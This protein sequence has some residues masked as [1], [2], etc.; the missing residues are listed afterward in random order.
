MEP[1]NQRG[2]KSTQTFDA[3][4]QNV[5]LTTFTNALE[6]D[7][8]RLAGRMSGANLLIW[9]SGEFSKH[10]G[11]GEV[12]VAPPEGVQL[13]VRQTT[14]PA[15]LS[16]SSAK[17]FGP[18]SPNLPTSPVP[19]GADLTYTFGPEWVDVAP[20]RIATPTTYAEFQGR[21]AYGERSDIPFHVN[22]SDW[23]DSDRVFAGILTAFGS[24]TGAIPIGG[25]GTFDGVMLN[26]FTRPRIEGDFTGAE[27]TAWDV[28]WG[29]ASGSAIIENSYANVKNVVISKGDSMIYADGLFSLGYPRKDGG[30]QLD[31]RVRIAGRPIADLRHAFELD[32]YD[33]DGVL[34][35]EFHV[36]GNYQTP[37]GFGTMS[38]D[39]GVAYGEPF[40][41]AL[42]TLRFDGDGVRLDN[43]QVVK[44]GGRGSG[45]AF[46]GWNSTYSFNF[47][48]HGIPVEQLAL[49]KG[50]PF[51]LSGLV[52]VTAKGS[53]SFAAP[54]YDVHGTIRDLFVKDEGI[55]QVVGDI[56]INNDLMTLK[57]EAAS[58][59]LA[60]S[61][62]GQIALN[63]QMD[64]ELT[65]NVSDT[66]LDPYLRVVEPS[67]SP[68][69]TAVASG[70]VR[71]VG[72]L[73]DFDHLLVDASVANLDL[74]LF[75]YR[76]RNASPIHVALDRGSV[77]LTEMRLVGEDTQLD[78]DGV[79]G[80]RD[81]RVAIR[82][83]GN[84]NLGI[85]QGFVAN[86]RSSGRAVLGA[87][88][89]GTIQDPAIIGMLTVENGRIRHFALPHALENISGPLSFDSR[90]VSLDGLTARLGGGPVTFAGR[91]DKQ[92]YSLGRID[93]SMTGK[94][95]RLRFP[96]GMRSLV[97]ATLTLQGS[98]EG[99]T[100]GGEV[101]VRDAVYSRPFETGGSLLDITGTGAGGASSGSAASVQEIPLRYDVRINA[102]STLQVRNNTA[103]LVASADLQLRGTY[104]RPLLFGRAEV[105]RGEVQFEGKRYLVTRGTI[106]F[107]NPTRIQPFFDLETETRVRVPG[108]TYRVTLRA[109]GTFDR[110]TLEFTSDP[111]LPEAQV[112][113][114]LF[115]DTVPNPDVELSQYTTGVTPQEQLLRERAT[116]ALTGAVSSEVGRVVE[117]TFGVDTFQLTPSLV[118]PNAQSTR[119]DPAARLTIGKRLSDRIYLTYARSLSST[120]RDQ[121]ILLEYDLSD[122]F[123]WILSRNEDRTYA[124]DV[125]VRHAF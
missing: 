103:R 69:T 12:H 66:S 116:R 52:D 4:Y 14:A 56:S 19:V 67:L 112:L 84:A 114:L 18:F 59:R 121:I 60:I 75:D 82:A 46:V 51:P 96:E 35:G 32:D 2:V 54:R 93:V 104:D 80:L 85:L 118:D 11:N 105:D 1:L 83:T 22:S 20:S 29:T 41:T 68:Y 86:V 79:V 124:L 119:L 64:A 38:I 61:G 81:N 125:R 28:D 107:N 97:D 43:I 91:I 101:Q 111:P 53:G 33:V 73:A 9:P 42:A 34:S 16:L 120:T 45:A 65:F 102:P 70:T 39:T 21:T 89:E 10:H 122:R 77:R 27:M 40:E 31:A 71:V 110:L 58:P 5:D 117:Q 108:E 95:M 7:G 36:Y 113:A 90:G 57:V 50:S 15:A 78:V 92:G 63:P 48:V 37:L 44:G 106:D 23:Q 17:V 123:S 94:E 8:I 87:T 100:L 30:E 13:A 3:S 72:E 47:D 76:L 74:H 115:S 6:V 99:A 98:A 55:G 62:A 26:S 109:T 88:V 49:T 24:R 25:R